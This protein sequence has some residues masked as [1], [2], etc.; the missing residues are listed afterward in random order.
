MDKELLKLLPQKAFKLLSVTETFKVGTAISKSF[1]DAKAYDQSIKKR[2]IND[3]FPDILLQKADLKLTSKSSFT[4]VDGEKILRVYFSQF[5]ENDVPVH[6]DLRDSSF[7]IDEGFTWIPSK[8]HYFFSTNFLEGVRL[9]Y[10]GF[11][12]E[13]DE[14]FDSGLRKL[15]IINS[16]MNEV[17]VAE[18]KK[19][20]TQHFGSGKNAPV[21]FSLKE[22][23]ESFNVIFS[24]FLKNDIALNPEFAVLGVCL[25]TLYLSLQSIPVPLDVSAAFKDVYSKYQL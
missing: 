14:D 17:Q 4:K 1:F 3:K 8:A 5:F 6:V 13:N 7:F 21:K 25:A 20:F 12:F 22:L 24:Y 9:L 10:A 19:L 16:S 18:V 23:Q 11:Y 2:H 15:G